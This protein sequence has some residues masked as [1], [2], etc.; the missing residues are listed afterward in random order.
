M[1][2]FQKKLM[3]KYHILNV[4]LQIWQCPD[5]NSGWKGE[6]L[7]SSQVPARWVWPEEKGHTHACK[8]ER[9]NSL[10]PPYSEALS[11]VQVLNKWAQ[12]CMYRGTPS[13]CDCC[14][15]RVLVCVQRRDTELWVRLLGIWCAGLIGPAHKETSSLQPGAVHPQSLGAMD[16]SDYMVIKIDFRSSDT[17]KKN[18]I[19]F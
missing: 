12:P 5:L 3:H 13:Q 9:Y 16:W 10:W 15:V 1:G 4:L 19:F 6:Q 11:A 2:S 14:F 18:K 17:W 7:W 8:Y